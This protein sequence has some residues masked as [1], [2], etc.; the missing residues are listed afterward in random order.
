ME[1]K[2][3]LDLVRVRTFYGEPAAGALEDEGTGKV[4]G[5]TLTEYGRLG[6]AT[7]EKAGES[8]CERPANHGCRDQEH[9]EHHNHRLIGPIHLATI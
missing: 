1:V 5:R 8:R 6:F 2:S 9:R 3:G 7:F 4:I